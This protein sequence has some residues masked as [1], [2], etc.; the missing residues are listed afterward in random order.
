MMFNQYQ[1]IAPLSLIFKLKGSVVDSACA[2]VVEG[3]IKA[4]KI[5]SVGDLR[6]KGGYHDW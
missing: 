3:R 1:K 5:P 2:D 4:Q 6:V